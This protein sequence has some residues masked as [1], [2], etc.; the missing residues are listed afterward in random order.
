M[1]TNPTPAPLSPEREAEIRPVPTPPS[2]ERLAEIYSQWAEVHTESAPVP[3]AWA[4]VGEVLAELE[5]VRAEQDRANAEWQARLDKANQRG[6]DQF[7]RATKAEAERD[8][9]EKRAADVRKAAINDVGGWLARI[10]E[11]G[12]AF[13]VRTCYPLEGG[14]R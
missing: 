3:P 1:T 5:R 9:L 11:T 13:I 7:R 12:A 14:A 6:T 8:E 10:G 4:A 2:L